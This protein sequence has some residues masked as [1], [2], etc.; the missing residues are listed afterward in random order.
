MAE[1]LRRLDADEDKIKRLLSI[2]FM[3]AARAHE[4]K[5][6]DILDV[7]ESCMTLINS[8]NTSKVSQAQCRKL[9]EENTTDMVK[10]KGVWTRCLR[11]QN[12]SLKSVKNLVTVRGARGAAEYHKNTNH[13]LLPV[14]VRDSANKL[15][16]SFNK[17]KAECLTNIMTE[18]QSIEGALTRI[19][20]ILDEW[21]QRP[22]PEHVLEATNTYIESINNWE[23]NLKQTFTKA[24][25]TDEEE[26]TQPLDMD[27]VSSLD[28]YSDDVALDHNGF[29]TIEGELRLLLGEVQDQ[30]EAITT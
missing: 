17:P 2:L 25:V 6:V 30:V 21:R 8:C 4:G 23:Q 29:N 18:L 24:G 19:Q 26:G 27:I 11:L 14:S 7:E 12:A 28:D 5:N 15:V 9:N 1:K 10:E 13:L 22:W 20:L 3:N 16:D